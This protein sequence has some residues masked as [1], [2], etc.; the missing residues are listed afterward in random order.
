MVRIAM[1]GQEPVAGEIIRAA[2]TAM[3]KHEGGAGMRRRVEALAKEYRRTRKSRIAFIASSVEIE[4]ARLN[5]RMDVLV[6]RNAPDEWISRVWMEI[7]ALDVAS[8]ALVQFAP[9]A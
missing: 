6:Q 7:H 1:T 8:N 3:L 4:R 2:E 5:R 9:E